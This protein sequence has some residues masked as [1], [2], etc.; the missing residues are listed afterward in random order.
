VRDDLA[1]V[2]EKLG[3]APTAE[4]TAKLSQYL[5]LLLRWNA[6]YNLTAVRDRESML[7]QH[8]SDC[9]AVIPAL[10]RSSQGGRLIDV[11]TGGGLPAVV[12]ATLL[13]AFDVTCVDGVAKKVAFV[14]QV[15]SEL[16]LGNL[17]PMHS[18][19]QDLRLPAFDVA[20][21]RAFGSLADFCNATRGLMA[22]AGIRLAMKGRV[23]EDEIAA[24]PDDVEVFHVEQLQVPGLDARRCLVWMRERGPG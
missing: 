18:R 4:Q 20:V 1:P 3:L 19:V 11:G 5:D 6:V 22:L 17:H 8:L 21:S 16:G 23:P 9:L 14:R 24:L 7:A 13:P 2:F 12:I 15:A 10:A